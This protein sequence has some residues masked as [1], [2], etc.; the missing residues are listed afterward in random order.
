L[1][2][3]DETEVLILKRRITHLLTAPS[4]RFYRDVATWDSFM[5]ELRIVEGERKIDEARP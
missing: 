2:L 1:S 3:P 5:N 4:S